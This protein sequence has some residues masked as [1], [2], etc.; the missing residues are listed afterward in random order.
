MIYGIMERQNLRL[1]HK[2]SN[3]IDDQ[4]H[5]DVLVALD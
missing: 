5:K 3:A 2:S 4:E 1:I